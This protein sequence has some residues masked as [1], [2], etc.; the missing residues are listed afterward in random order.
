MNKPSYQLRQHQLEE[1]L[2]EGT[3]LFQKLK[4]SE[5]E[6]REHLIK[7]DHK[8]LIEAE[9]RRSNIKEKITEMED[10]RKAIIP[11]GK[12]LQGYIKSMVAKSSQEIFLKKQAAVMSVLRDIKALHEVNRILLK[13]RLRFS[14]ELQEILADSRLTYNEHGQLKDDKQDS[15]NIDRSC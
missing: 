12:G 13:E 4:H 11:E 7:G 15:S 6:L 10:K 9:E 2:D 14:K 8:A 3:L 5:E 1:V